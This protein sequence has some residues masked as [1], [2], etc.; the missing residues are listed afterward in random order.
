MKKKIGNLITIIA[1][2]VGVVLIASPIAKNYFI[3]DRMNLYQIKKV[4]KKDI[5]KN[6]KKK[7]SYDWDKVKSLDTSS[8]IKL[9]DS[10]KGLPVIGAI[11][12]PELK[13][14]LPIYKGVSDENMSY[15]ASTMSNEQEMGQGNY[16]L[17]SHHVFGLANANK[18]LFSP[19]DNA[20]VGQK[21]YITDKTNV[22]QY[23]INEIFTV[24]PSQTDVVNTI[25]GRKVITLITCTDISGSGRLIV[26]GDLV[27]SYDF[28]TMPEDARNGFNL[29]YQTLAV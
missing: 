15:G 5:A 26:R 24:S 8:V 27:A 14:N 1:V 19:L 6:K 25:E 21:I 10:P 16:S 22:Y 29:E 11:T 18:L 12:V 13:M 7:V 20:K 17:I 9:K 23:N 2:I 28:K 4:S 3:A